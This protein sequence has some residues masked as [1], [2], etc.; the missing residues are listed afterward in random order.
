M[1]LSL[2]RETLGGIWH[3]TPLSDLVESILGS[4]FYILAWNN[5]HRPCIGLAL[6]FL[7][8]LS[9]GLSSFFLSLEDVLVHQG[10]TTRDDDDPPSQWEVLVHKHKANL[11]SIRQ[12]MRKGKTTTPQETET[13]SMGIKWK[14]EKKVKHEDQKQNSTAHHHSWILGYPLTPSFPPPLSPDASSH[15]A[16]HPIPSHPIN[17]AESQR[18]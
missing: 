9:L 8:S 14:Q 1:P 11:A 12:I 2:Q 13:A 7:A 10:R 15:G 17:Q 18:E 6:F 16:S 3:D 4:L 5:G